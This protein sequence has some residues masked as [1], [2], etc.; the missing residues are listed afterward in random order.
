MIYS[1]AL[2]INVLQNQHFSRPSCRR[3]GLYGSGTHRFDLMLGYTVYTHVP[4]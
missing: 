1:L 4:V 2:I 3:L